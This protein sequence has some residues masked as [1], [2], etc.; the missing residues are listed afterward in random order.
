MAR[1]VIGLLAALLIAFASPASAQQNVIGPTARTPSGFSQCE[2]A[3]GS[4]AAGPIRSYYV[5]MRD[6]VRIAVDVVLPAGAASQRFPAILEMT[7]YWRRAQ[8][9]P[10]S[11]EEK[12]FTANGFAVVTGDVRGTGASFGVWPYH[13]SRAETL[14]FGEIL[15]WIAKQPWSDGA[16]AGYGVSYSAN[17]ADWF[18]ERG[19]PALK[20]I[21]PRFPDYD[22][23]ADL[24]FPGG[25]PN[26]WMAETWGLAVKQM[27]INQRHGADG[28]ALPGI[29]PV[30]GDTHQSLLGQA[31]QE[32]RD[33]PSVYEGLKQ[34]IF[35]DDRPALWGGASMD[36]WS[37]FSVGQRIDRFNIPV[38]AWGSW[39]DSGVANGVLHRFM[40]Q[41]Y[42]QRA[43]LGAWT[44]GGFRSANP[45]ASRNAPADPPF[46]AQMDE[47]LCFLDRFTKLPETKTLT[48][49]KLL[50]Y[51]TIGEER[52]KTTTVW[53]P[54]Q[55]KPQSWYFA[56]GN[57]LTVQKPSAS[58]GSDKY[59]VDFTATTGATNRWH[60][61]GGV[62][63]VWYGDRAIE[64]RKLLTYTSEPLAHDV[65]ITGVPV[66]DLYVAADGTDGAF[67]L[68][69]EDIDPQGIVRYLTEGELRGIDRKLSTAP[70]VYRVVGPYHS[71]QRADRLPLRPAQVVE[72]KFSLMPIS[73]LLRAGHRIRIALAGADA[74][75]FARIPN[76]G[77]LTYTVYHERSQL[78]RIVLPVV[79]KDNG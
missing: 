68:Y 13:R 41:R 27:D 46:S 9:D 53:P 29:R 44:H 72:L 20:A 49:R 59:L 63:E 23:Y 60:T 24:Y 5:T 25:I 31:I 45:Y 37:I 43:Y 16:V 74:D 28:R 58:T 70:P 21:V 50:S 3:R 2:T 79:T 4:L 42:P 36:D 10:V 54:P 71:F 76:A 57:R 48:P 22:P 77:P 6:G 7:R 67:F 26:R 52:W 51:Y 18:A 11:D 65:E 35:R 19:N 34:I 30:D 15:T 33:L 39:F 64:D 14:D 56:A 73:A 75:T 62:E 61:N 55:E 8:G 38:Q 69:L 1:I 78:S 66:A 32:R 12:T 17:T 47:D 40:T